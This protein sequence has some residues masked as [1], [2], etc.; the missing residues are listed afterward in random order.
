MPIRAV[1]TLPTENQLSGG[2]GRSLRSIED[3]R[4]ERFSD[5]Q[6]LGS[7]GVKHRLGKYGIDA[8]R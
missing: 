5:V 3:E 6:R 7:D 1:E 2:L 8:G 4:C